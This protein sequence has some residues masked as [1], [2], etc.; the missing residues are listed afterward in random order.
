MRLRQQTVRLYRAA[1]EDDLFTFAAALAYHLMLALFPFLFFLIAIAAT[2]NIGGI[3]D[4]LLS[5]SRMVL[6]AQAFGQILEVVDGLR[7][8]GGPALLSLGVI[9]AVWAASGGVRSAMTALNRAYDID[10]PRGTVKR[11]L[12]SLGYTVALALLVVCGAALLFVGPEAAQWIEQELQLG[13]TFVLIWQW[14]RYPLIIALLIVGSALAYSF[15]PNGVPFRLISAGSVLAISLWLII[16]FGF[17]WYI[18]NFGRF[19]VV[20]GS[21]GAMIVLLIYIYLSSLAL[22]IGGELNA[23]RAAEELSGQRRA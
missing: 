22:L 11:Y 9:G 5:W 14:L 8:G 13:G 18:A 19:N 3:I 20:Y 15:L 12:V 4:R 1:L 21:I 16:S 23:M 2:L 6:P 10:Q 17:R 7:R